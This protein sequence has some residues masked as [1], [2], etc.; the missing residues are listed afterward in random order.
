M[1]NLSDPD[2][3]KYLKYKKKYT[4][5]KQQLK[6]GE[7]GSIQQIRSAIGKAASATASVASSAASATASVASSAAKVAADAAH[8][9]AEKG[10]Q[11]ARIASDAAHIAAE[12]ST[13][14]A[15]AA[16]AGVVAIG[17]NVNSLNVTSNYDA[18]RADYLKSPNDVSKW[19]KA[20]KLHENCEV[21]AVKIG[22][23]GTCDKFDYTKPN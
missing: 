1:T 7:P 15:K 23:A 16:K 17:D 4:I 10:A 13:K 22:K 12:K 11:A 21:A 8:V 20:N 5:L 3:Q 2:Y 18:A 14:A 19:E 9:A 6:G